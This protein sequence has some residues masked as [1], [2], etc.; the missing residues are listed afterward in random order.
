L[1]EDDHS[2]QQILSEDNSAI[3]GWKWTS[4]I[5][6]KKQFLV[7]SPAASTAVLGPFTSLP[8]N[9]NNY[10]G[11]RVLDALSADFGSKLPRD[12]FDRFCGLSNSLSTA[13]QQDYVRS[14]FIRKESF[15]RKPVS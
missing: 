5:I 7:Q 4:P 6:W 8:S 2:W 10:D 1:S 3:A 13:T 15:H 14:T 12:P 9:H 11:L